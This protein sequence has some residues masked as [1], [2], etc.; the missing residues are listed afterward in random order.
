MANQ[1]AI[2]VDELSALGSA[3][4]DANLRNEPGSRTPQAEKN[5]IIAQLRL[6]SWLETIAS[7]S[8]AYDLSP[9][10]EALV[11][12]DMGRKRIRAL[13]LV[14]RSLIGERHG[15]QKGLSD[16]LR[17]IFGDKVVDRWSTVADANDLLS[18]TT[19][20]ELASIFVNKGF[21]SHDPASCRRPA[22]WQV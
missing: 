17:L 19:F 2:S 16:H 6:F 22:T 7:R 13:E 4:A 15:D 1:L 12:E 5:R 11:S 3:V 14:I 20:S 18:G 8:S 9:Q 21:F 10:V